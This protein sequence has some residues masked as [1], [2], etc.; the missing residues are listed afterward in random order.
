MLPPHAAV[1]VVLGEDGDERLDDPQRARAVVG[2]AERVLD[3]HALE[4]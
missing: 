1:L 3:V 2:A 4:A